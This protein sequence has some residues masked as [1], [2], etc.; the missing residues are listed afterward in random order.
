MKIFI[1]GGTGFLGYHAALEC[2]R[3]GY[4]V[5]TISLPDIPLGDWFPK[6]I[7]V[8]YGNV[9]AMAE[10]E[11]INLFQGFD[12]IIYTVGPDDRASREA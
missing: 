9:F 11:L 2:L 5:S 6:E 3:R 7:T 10:E 8:N 4:E 12:A 1:V